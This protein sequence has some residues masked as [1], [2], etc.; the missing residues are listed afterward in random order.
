MSCFDLN[1]IKKDKNTE[2]NYHFE[3]AIYTAQVVSQKYLLQ[4]ISTDFPR[5]KLKKLTRSLSY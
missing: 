1:Y 5:W 4:T 2:K 3:R